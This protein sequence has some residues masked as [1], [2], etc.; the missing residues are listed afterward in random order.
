MSQTVLLIDD[1]R[2]QRRA[3][4]L[5]ISKSGYAVLVA[6]D[7]NQGLILARDSKPDVIV[8]DMM[9]PGISGPELLHILKHDPSTSSIPVIVLSGL[10]RANETKLKA[11]GATVYLQK[12]DV[13]IDTGATVLIQAIERVLPER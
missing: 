1:S 8:L 9:L 6:P 4:E 12:S 2:F 5:A 11:E 13:G 7:G 10:S 3:T